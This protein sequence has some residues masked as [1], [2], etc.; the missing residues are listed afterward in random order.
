MAKVTPSTVMVEMGLEKSWY[1]PITDE[2][3]AKKPV[4][5]EKLDMGAAVKAYL[6]VTIASASIPGDNITQVEV[7][8]F[9]SGQLD[10]ETTMSELE[11]NAKIYGHA[12]TEDGGEVSSAGDTAPNGG[13]AMVQHILK[14]DKTKVYRATCLHKVTAMAGSEKQNADTKKSGQLTFANNAVSY[15]VMADNTNAWRTRQDFNTAAEATAF[16]E[17]FYASESESSES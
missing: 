14:K 11:V 4:Y 5:G 13:Y 16:I 7:E 2:P 10:A 9:V 15:K 17:A 6:S 8:E 12:Y 3:E 1:F